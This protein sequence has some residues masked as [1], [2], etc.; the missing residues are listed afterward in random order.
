MTPLTLRRGVDKAVVAA[1]VRFSRCKA[2]ERVDIAG[3][4]AGERK[5]CAAVGPISVS[6]SAIGT[7][8]PGERP[9]QTGGL[10][11]LQVD[12]PGKSQAL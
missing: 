12:G 2:E 4:G 6:S 10:A 9:G 7:L 5:V 1:P 3:I 11:G 8:P